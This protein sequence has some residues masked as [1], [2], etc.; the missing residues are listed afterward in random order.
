M[1]KR[2]EG[3]GNPQFGAIFFPKQGEAPPWA[4]DWRKKQKNRQKEQEGLQ[5]CSISVKL[6]LI[7][8]PRSFQESAMSQKSFSPEPCAA[9]RRLA[10]AGALDLFAKTPWPLG[11]SSTVYSTPWP[12]TQKVVNALWAQ[13]AGR[14]LAA[15]DEPWKKSQDGAEEPFFEAWLRFASPALR[16]S[17][18]AIRRFFPERYPTAGS[19]EAIRE[20]IHQLAAA[21]SR[22][23]A[24]VFG[25]EYEGYEA[26]ASAAGVRVLKIDRAGWREGLGALAADGGLDWGRFYLSH[27]SSIDGEPWGEIEAFLDALDATFGERLRVALDLTY[28]GLSPKLR[29]A[30]AAHAAVEQIFFSLSKPFGVYYRRIG[31]VFSR[32]PI[33]TLWGNRWFKALDALSIG[34]AL[35]RSRAE[36]HSLARGAQ[37]AQTL[38]IEWAARAHK[39]ALAELG[40]RLAPADVP[41]LARLEPLP[42]VDASRWDALAESGEG[43]AA[44]LARLARRKGVGARAASWRLCLSPMI[45]ELIKA[46]GESAET[47]LSD[48]WQEVLGAWRNGSGRPESERSRSAMRQAA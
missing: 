45:G 32:K 16:P 29:E 31:G 4:R 39:A 26:L 8:Q 18:E 43:P 17:L 14:L 35:L 42:G 23:V 27:P 41:L 36:P 22:G 48:P 3:R 24:V 5:G 46:S 7:E 44:A 11:L 34:E 21:P 15:H 28:L 1:G 12:S 47:W 6:Q 20:S 33:P 37:K 30:P 25:G 19:S 9:A 13:E 2:P 40:A 10:A 38:A